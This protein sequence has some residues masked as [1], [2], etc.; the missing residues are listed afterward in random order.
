MATTETAKRLQLGKRRTG[1][2]LALGRALIVIPISAVV[3]L[4]VL[5]MF[6]IQE[7]GPEGTAVASPLNLIPSSTIPGVA[8]ILLVAPGQDVTAVYTL[9]NKAEVASVSPWVGIHAVGPHACEQDW[10]ARAKHWAKLD[11]FILEPGEFRRIEGTLQFTEVGLYFGETTR[12]T[13]G[14]T[15]AGGYGRCVSRQYFV[16][17]DENTLKSVDTSC[18]ANRT[19]QIGRQILLTAPT[20]E[21]TGC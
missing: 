19:R 4:V 16:V 2:L 17:G 10:K 21:P 15:S 18:V 6:F 9:T 12:P 20:D 1:C 8:G 5:R 3:L 13:P 7:P 11:N 14:G